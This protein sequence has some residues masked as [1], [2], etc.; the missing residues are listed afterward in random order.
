MNNNDFLEVETPMMQNIPGGASARPFITYHNSLNINLYLR[1][2]PELY[3]KRLV[4]GGFDRIFEI[5]KNFRNEGLSTRHNPEFTMME[6]YMSYTNY[7]DTMLFIEK[8]F[9]NIA[10]KLYN[11]TKIC[12]GNY[13]FDFSKKFQ[14]F[15]MK[16]SIVMFN[17]NIKLS[18]LDNLEITK[19]ILIKL[20]IKIKPHWKIGHF[21]SQIF[22]KTVEKK[23]NISYVYH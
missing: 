3:L 20:N 10:K 12:Y 4:V 5:N 11:T 2:S 19:N 15:T 23:T 6:L 22:E 9:K 21:I 14:R 18:D 17:E 16:E 7:K 1:I 8:L 13:T